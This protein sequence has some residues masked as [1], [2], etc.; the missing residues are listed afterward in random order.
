MPI[1]YRRYYIQRLNET[2]E[3]QNEE[4]NKKFNFNNN[5]GLVND[6]PMKSNKLPP[7]PIPDFAT[8]ARA[9]KK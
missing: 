2:V 8:N 5:K 1:R 9:P 3:Q 7:P 4:M 6:N